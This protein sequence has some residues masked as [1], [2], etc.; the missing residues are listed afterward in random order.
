M[1]FVTPYVEATYAELYAKLRDKALTNG[2]AT[3]EELPGILA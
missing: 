1:L 3:M 2:Y